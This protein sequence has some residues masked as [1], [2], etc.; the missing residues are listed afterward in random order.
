MARHAEL[1][2]KV[3][4]LRITGA[5]KRKGFSLFKKKKKKLVK[6]RAFLPVFEAWKEKLGTLFHLSENQ[7]RCVFTV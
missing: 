4:T 7:Y 5:K 3:A 1:K 2:F 6:M